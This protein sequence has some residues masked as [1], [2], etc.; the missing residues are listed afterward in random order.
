MGEGIP[1]G[2]RR[3]FTNRFEFEQFPSRPRPGSD[4]TAFRFGTTRKG[5]KQL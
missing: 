5:G 2:F 1:H 4:R 3:F